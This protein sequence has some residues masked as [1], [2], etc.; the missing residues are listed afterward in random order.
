[1]TIM[2]ETEQMLARVEDGIG[3]MTFNRPE[4]RNALSG[5]MQRV[6]PAILETFQADP[7]VRVVVMRGAGDKAFVAGADIG[8]FGRE[9]G[10]PRRDGGDDGRPRDGFALLE[11]PLIAMIR[12]YALGAGLLTAL[13]ADIRI[14]AEDG[15]FGIPAARLGLGYGFESTK[16]IVDAVGKT[17]AAEILLTGRQFS[18]EEA[19]RLGLVSRVVPVDQLEPTVRELASTIA[20]N[21]PL[22]VRLVRESIRQSMLEPE[23]RDMERVRAM[24]VDCAESDDFLEGRKAFAEKRRPQFTGR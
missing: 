18:A 9:R 14:T 22:T 3:W 21:A 19:L 16:A 15:R 12:G 24:A 1:M 13:R 4:R 23:E 17:A 8:E 7:D 2:L 11:K 20:E 5:E 10:M 6:I